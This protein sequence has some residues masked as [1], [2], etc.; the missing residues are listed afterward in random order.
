MSRRCFLATARY[1]RATSTLRSDENGVI[2]V[3]TGPGFGVDIDP[4]FLAKCT[5]VS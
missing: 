5:V 4:D 2:K 3:P 1:P